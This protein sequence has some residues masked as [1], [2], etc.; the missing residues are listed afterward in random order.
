MFNFWINHL[1]SLAI[2][3]CVVSIITIINLLT[4]KK[5]KRYRLLKD[6]P[7][8]S[9]LVPARNEENNI[10][11]CVRSLLLQAYPRLEILVLDDHSTDRTLN[12][13]RELQKEYP[14]LKVMQ[15]QPLPGGWL[16]KHWACHQLFEASTGD[17]VLFTDADTTHNPETLKQ[18][19]SAICLERADMLT[20][21]VHLEIGSVGEGLLVPF[22]YWSLLTFFPLKLA[23]KIKSQKISASVGQ[24]ILFKRIAYEQIGGYAAIKNQILDDF[25]LGR[26]ILQHKL[27]WCFA[28]A[29]DLVSCRMYTSLEEAVRGFS[30]SLFAVFNRKILLFIFVFLYLLTLYFEPIIVLMLRIMNV[31]PPSVPFAP[32]LASIILSILQQWICYQ[33]MKIPTLYAFLYPLSILVAAF[34]AFHSLWSH[35]FKTAQWKGRR[36]GKV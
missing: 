31:S 8:V 9:V 4:I 18:A 12:I 22:M 35:I 7:R 15:G 3:L 29:I 23:A 17:F 5:I 13:L 11:R 6:F 2:F 34:T 33:R 10:G 19:V 26:N 28:D 20:A 32:L 14:K 27:N 21:M 25:L 24:F 36:V 1:Y 30:K 16:G